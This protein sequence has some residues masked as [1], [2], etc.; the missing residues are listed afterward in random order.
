MSL[1]SGYF[2]R[3]HS[4][5]SNSWL[6]SQQWRQQLRSLLVSDVDTCRYLVHPHID[7]THVHSLTVAMD[8]YE[9]TEKIIQATKPE[10]GGAEH[11]RLCEAI[12]WL[13]NIFFECCPHNNGLELVIFEA[14]L[15]LSANN[16]GDQSVL[17]TYSDYR[18]KVPVV[19][20][21]GTMDAG[22]TAPEGSAQ[23]GG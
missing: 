23:H 19:V 7:L 3:H 11:L 12:F 16:G 8:S 1:S 15:N 18:G 4:D 22:F 10:L 2:T 9:L 5:Q 21:E 20:R 17:W 13:M 6:G 14:P